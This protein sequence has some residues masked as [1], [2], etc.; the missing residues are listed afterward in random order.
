MRDTW[1]V[2]VL[3][4]RFRTVKRISAYLAADRALLP[5]KVLRRLDAPGTWRR[6]ALRAPIR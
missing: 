4:R 2:Q 1:E 6:A 5:A 3:D